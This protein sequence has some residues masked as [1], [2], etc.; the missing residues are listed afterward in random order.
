M[1]NLVL[2]NII[3][4]AIKAHRGHVLKDITDLITIKYKSLQNLQRNREILLAPN[5]VD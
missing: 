2:M 4:V 5:S 1:L 3:L